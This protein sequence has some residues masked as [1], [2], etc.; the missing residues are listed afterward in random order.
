M[1]DE[2]SPELKAPDE[3]R[4]RE[5]MDRG[6][7]LRLIVAMAAVLW[8]LFCCLHLM[9]KFIPLEQYA[10]STLGLFANPRMLTAAL[11]EAML[12]WYSG[13]LEPWHWQLGGI[14]WLPLLFACAMIAL[15]T[16]VGNLAVNC[17]EIYVPRLMRLPINYVAG[18]GAMSVLIELLAMFR[19]L[20]RWPIIIMFALA[21]IVF[22][23]MS[24]LAM[25]RRKSDGETHQDPRAI[26]S[27][28]VNL[29]RKALRESLMP[30][31]R[32]QFGLWI[33]LLSASGLLLLLA[34]FHA[35]FFAET[36]WDSLILYMGYGRMTYLQ[37]GFPFK[38]VAHVGYGL[39]ANYPHLY[40]LVGS[41]TAALWG[42]WHDVFAQTAP[43][44]CAMLSTI[45]I[46]YTA[47]EVTRSRLAGAVLALLFRTP[48][49]A[50][51]Y[52]MYASD[53]AVA[54]LFTAVFLYLAW[55]YLETAL[56][57]YLVLLTFIPAFAMHINY[58]MGI[59]WLPWALTVLTV[60][61]RPRYG[62]LESIDNL[63]EGDSRVRRQA[64]LPFVVNGTCPPL[65]CLLTAKW[66]W[67]LLIIAGLTAGTWHIRNWALTGNPV[68]AFFHGVFGGINYNEDVMQSADYEWT[69]NGDGVG[70]Y[71]WQVWRN[72]YRAQIDGDAS[73]WA[74]WLKWRE[75][76]KAENLLVKLQLS[77]SF[78]FDS[79]NHATK[80]SP[81]L[82]G[83]GVPG[84]LIWL[85][86]LSVAFF[87]RRP[88]YAELKFGAV[89][90]LVV[91]SMLGFHYA[92]GDYYQYQILPMLPALSLAPV[93]CLWLTRG[94]LPAYG[95]AAA[96]LLVALFPALPFSL[97]GFK[98]TGATELE[99][100]V[101][102]WM[103]MY[104]L[105]HLGMSA[106]D[107]RRLRYDHDVE[108]WNLVNSVCAGKTPEEGAVILTH[109]NRHLAYHPSITLFHMDEPEIWPLW[110]LPVEERWRRLRDMEVHESDGKTVKR[111]VDYYLYIPNE[112]HNPINKRLGVDEWLD[113]PVMELITI[114]RPLHLREPYKENLTAD[115]LKQCNRLY[116]FHWDKISAAE[117]FTSK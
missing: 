58:L 59:L 105:R 40:P 51:A 82:I 21:I 74:I 84:L 89:I 115:D 60:H 73:D 81:A 68:Y 72:S 87:K 117:E 102:R 70:G 32:W 5:P 36:Y 13:L 53:Y 14:A 65:G 11:R 48:V 43:P 99:G 63:F 2:P 6:E 45:T 10:D 23:R 111:G 27:G 19:L 77:K 3:E 24:W 42:G 54:I 112:E 52:A 44:W 16:F 33:A 100:E 30:L 15:Y 28:Q 67:T 85:G 34:A 57:G 55:K 7:W 1:E 12:P 49:Y 80:F 69:L 29:A 93:F 108:I 26:S 83:F 116:K 86:L 98:A 90:A 88:V 61:L 101:V 4:P 103:D 38:A 25:M 106:D 71:A 109:E 22:W 37:H 110:D 97:L 66:F 56:R 17:C 107:M 41:T 104:P 46:Y 75:Q 62:E 47:T 39:G 20:Y 8:A 64:P 92:L 9:T 91:A 113:T 35:I 96:L 18:L 94:R 95:M 114:T 78:W 50:I 76:S 31:N 79:R